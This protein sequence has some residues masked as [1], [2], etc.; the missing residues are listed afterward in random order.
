MYEAPDELPQAEAIVV[1]GGNP[2][3]N[4]SLTGESAERFQMGL[5]LFNNGVAPVMI[6]TGGGEQPVAEAM[7]QAALAAGIP[8]AALL[9]ETASKSTLQNALFSADLG[10]D[11]GVPIVIVTH[12]YH[13]PRAWA[14]FQWAGYSQVIRHAADADAA[15]AFSLPV[16]MESIKWPVN[17][18][19]AGAATASR[20]A[21]VPRE[22]YIKYLE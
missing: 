16:F 20:M 9:V 5:E 13:L 11:K 14:S 18:V 19:R 8:D 17:V 7:H 2:P 1:L 12:R 10:L 4:G 21:G 22:N 15:N 6:L 3:V